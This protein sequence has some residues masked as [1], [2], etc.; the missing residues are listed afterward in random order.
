M[1]TLIGKVACACF[2]AGYIY[3]VIIE[4]RLVLKERR[5]IK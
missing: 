2:V 1:K 3:G 5:R 4:R